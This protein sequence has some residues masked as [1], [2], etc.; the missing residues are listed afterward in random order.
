M[1][2]TF[3]SF[4]HAKVGSNVTFPCH[5]RGEPQPIVAW[6]KETALDHRPNRG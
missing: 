2:M 3:S 5:V 6:S 4:I 1:N